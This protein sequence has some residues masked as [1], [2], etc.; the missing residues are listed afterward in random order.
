M[1][2]IELMI[3]KTTAKNNEYSQIL[4]ISVDPKV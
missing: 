2:H 1:C 4:D 3:L